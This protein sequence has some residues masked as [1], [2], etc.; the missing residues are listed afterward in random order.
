MLYEALP[1]DERQTWSVWHLS[2]KGEP[3][4]GP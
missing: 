3:S 1:Y 4:H 2:V